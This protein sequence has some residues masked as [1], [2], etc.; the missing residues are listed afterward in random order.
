MKRIILFAGTIL[1]LCPPFISAT[2]PYIS[3]RSQATDSAR[4]I[5]GITDKINLYDMENLYITGA[6]TL[7]GTRSFDSDALAHCLF[8]AFTPDLNCSDQVSIGVSG[9][10]VPNRNP[11]DWLA[12]PCTVCL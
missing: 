10:Q 6:V 3:I 12:E 4:D 7:E 5:V 9:S 11:N 8:G 1:L 2:V